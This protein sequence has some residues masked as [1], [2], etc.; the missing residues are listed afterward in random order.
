MVSLIA[1]GLVLD[2][3]LYCKGLLLQRF[4]LDKLLS[5]HAQ[6]SFQS[7]DFKKTRPAFCWLLGLGLQC[8]N[9]YTLKLSIANNMCFVCAKCYVYI[10]VKKCKH[11]M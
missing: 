5:L 8:R 3:V 9:I 1:Q 10:C 11:Y 2:R 7:S 6:K 4:L